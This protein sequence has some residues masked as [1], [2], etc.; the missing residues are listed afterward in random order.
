ME[1]GNIDINNNNKKYFTLTV[2]REW[3]RGLVQNTRIYVL[4]YIL[5]CQY[6]YMR[7][8]ERPAHMHTDDI[9]LLAS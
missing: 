3:S 1:W 7:T 8:I 2:C 9:I 5:I 6:D 4:I